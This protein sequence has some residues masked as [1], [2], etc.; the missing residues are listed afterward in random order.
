MNAAVAIATTELR[1]FLRE[2]SNLFFVFVLP[3]L[4]VIFI[5]I[6][7]GGGAGTPVAVVV[8]AD[9]ALATE[10]AEELD[11]RDGLR[12]ERFDDAETA[13]EAVRRGSLAAAIVVPDG[14]SAAAEDGTLLPV[15]LVLRPGSDVAALRGVV[16]AVLGP[17]AAVLEAARGA[18]GLLADAD[19]AQL[20]RTAEQLRG[21]VPRVEVT[22]ATVGGGGGL[23]EEFAGLGQF[24]LG[25]SS[26]L[27]LFVFLT[28]LAGSAAVIQ[29]RQF[30]VATRMRATPTPVGAILAG[31]VG[32]RF[33][34]AVLQAVY[35]VVASRLLFGVDWG[36]PLATTV[37]VG[38]F[39]LVA[40]GAAVI[41]GAVFRNDSQAGGAGVGLGLVLAALGGSMV[42]L[43]VFP[44]GARRVAMATP[45]GWANTA[46]AELV[47]RD[48][49]VGD[50]L[51]EYAVL[52]AMA[53]VTLLVGTW[54]LRRALARPL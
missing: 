17:R 36:D 44:E 54:L 14:Y 15:R 6:Q 7:F 30:G 29:T 19:P 8:P 48:G 23:E 10:V 40:A 16:E 31:L 52:A 47:R 13:T 53:A 35:I 18:A 11:A 5:G 4:L 45:H 1:R 25:A 9:D 33:V 42:P 46:M 39:C 34:V 27:F 12:T 43:E 41:L 37:L 2:R 38:L 51:T 26:Q 20:R 50:V 32:G 21:V 24:D 49:G 3:L 22:T 28:S